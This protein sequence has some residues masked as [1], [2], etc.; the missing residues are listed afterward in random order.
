M[1]SGMSGLGIIM[2]RILATD[3]VIVTILALP[4]S[5][6]PKSNNAELNLSLDIVDNV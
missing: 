4:D 6:L 1:S 5:I 2:F 3:Y